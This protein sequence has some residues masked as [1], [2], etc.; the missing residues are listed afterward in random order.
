M[1]YAITVLLL[2][3]TLIASA[4]EQNSSGILI[5]NFY[6]TKV[7]MVVQQFDYI[8]EDTLPFRY[9]AKAGAKF[10]IIG[11][12][13]SEIIIKFWHFNDTNAQSQPEKDFAKEGSQLLYIDKSANDKHFV[14]KTDV[15]NGK[16]ESYNGKSTSFVWGITTLP[17]KLRFGNSDGR[18]FQ[19]SS[20]FN[21]GTNAGIQWTFKGRKS[22]NLNLLF[23]VGISSVQVDSAS[24]E[25]KQRESITAAAFTPSLGVV[26]G[27]ER[28]Q[29]GIYTGMDFTGGALSKKWVYQSKPWLAVGIGFALFQKDK[30]EEAGQGDN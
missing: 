18:E 24:T 12:K 14:V 27:Y 20:N 16:A 7:D 21:I 4:Q 2:C 9:I 28:M 19:F 26:Y 22:Q 11:I 6:R 29:V 5:G 10:T 30:Q 17:V 23:G 8:K 13:N 25:G 1:K 3:Y 15:L